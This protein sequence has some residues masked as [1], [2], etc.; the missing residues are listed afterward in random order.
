MCSI[1]VTSGGSGP[2]DAEASFAS[3]ETHL[4][5]LDARSV[6][7]TI[8]RFR[9]RLDAIEASVLAGGV[10]ANGDATTATRTIA[11]TN[12][13][14]RERR[15]RVNRARVVA[16]NQSLAE[17]VAGGELTGEHLDVIA[18]AASRTDGA[19]AHAPD[20]IAKVAATTPDQ[21]RKVADEWVADQLSGDD[22]DAEH[23]RQRRLR[24]ARRTT[25]PGG[26][27]SIILAGDKVSIDKMWAAISTLSDK[28]YRD[29]GGRDLNCEKHPRTSLQRHYDATVELISNPTDRT[30]PTGSRPKIVIT[31]PITKV[32]GA[33]P[34]APAIQVGVG[35]IADRVLDDHWCNAELIG[36]VFGTDGQP[37]WL[38][39][40]VRTASAAQLVAL[41][42][43]DQQCVLCGADHRRC[44]AHHLIPY[45]AP[46]RGPS[47]IDNLA[48]LCGPCHR[49]L[50]E[51]QQTLI[52][53]PN[54]TWE[55]RLATTQ[56]TP[57]R[58]SRSTPSVTP[59]V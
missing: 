52:R 3:L 46:I 43:R 9:D 59:I 12:L 16:S 30:R 29:D 1:N 47:D 19:A 55:T 25:A 31:V 48:L 58:K 5:N 14:S 4:H 21:A 40:S 10:L 6:V 20:L 51:H 17:R 39:Q 36:A 11:K 50:H 2:A 49:Q 56:E 37:L 38:G 22:I 41:T 28:Y 18:S 57:P 53:G 42:T 26:L 34:G 7:Q 35:P 54:N 44:E 33:K 13:S 23:Q 15:R 27:G 32:N 45:N 8:A 24:T